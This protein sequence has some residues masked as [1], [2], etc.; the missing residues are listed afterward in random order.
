[1]EI[2][3]V[4]MSEQRVSHD[5]LPDGWQ[6]LGGRGL[7]AKIM[8]AEVSA[9]ADPL[10]PENKLIICGG[11]LAGTFAPQLGRISIG[12][13]SPLP[14]V[15]GEELQEIAFETSMDVANMVGNPIPPTESRILEL[16]REFY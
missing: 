6:F 12:A 9:G 10:G 16:L 2:L 14:G 7:I 5:A 11:P 15:K 13:K 8:N 4:D 3:R 1:M